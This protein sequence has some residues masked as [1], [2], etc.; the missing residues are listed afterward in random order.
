MPEANL[1]AVRRADRK[2]D[3]PAEM[4]LSD[5]RDLSLPV[6][7]DH[8]V[9]LVRAYAQLEHVGTAVL[10]SLAAVLVAIRLDFDDPGGTSY[11]YT[12]HAASIYRE[13]GIPPSDKD[14]TQSAVRY[15]I[16][17]I[18]RSTVPQAE[19]VSL[20]LK[21]K[22]AQERQRDRRK[23]TSALVSS[24]RAAHTAEQLT[25]SEDG[26]RETPPSKDVADHLRL[27]AMMNGII[28]GM[29]PDVITG[30]MTPGQRKELDSRLA[31][32]IKSA[33]SVR[34]TIRAAGKR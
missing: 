11:A 19:I 10:K 13:A 29:Q 22:S 32:L 15:H 18:L 3:V 24:A 23:T 33:Q 17:A 31:L 14:R 21:P 28:G 25:P 34:A 26:T 7:T 20:G 8:A 4:S 5:A 1:P 9:Y 30:E 2:A 27:A 12:Q 16:S 6:L